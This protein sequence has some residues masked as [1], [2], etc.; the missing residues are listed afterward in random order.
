MPGHAAGNEA[1]SA[2]DREGGKRVA[3]AGSK[4]T[5]TSTE[6]SGAECPRQKRTARE[7]Y[8]HVSQPSFLYTNTAREA[9]RRPE[10]EMLSNGIPI[11]LV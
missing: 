11:A 7:V 2:D 4:L 3:G 8:Y 9:K 5:R 1:R 6:G 10:L